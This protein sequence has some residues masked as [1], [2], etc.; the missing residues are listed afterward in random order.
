M[1]RY[2]KDLETLTKE[3]EDAMLRMKIRNLIEYFRHNNTLILI[4]EKDEQYNRYINFDN[5]IF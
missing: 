2:N 4:L 3:S 5:F 1:S